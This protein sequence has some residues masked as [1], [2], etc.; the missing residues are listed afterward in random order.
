MTLRCDGSKQVRG[1]SSQSTTAFT[2]E[3]VARRRETVQ[4]RP[5]LVGDFFTRW[6]GSAPMSVGWSRG[7]S[8]TPAPKAW[9]APD[10]CAEPLLPVTRLGIR[11]ADSLK[12]GF[13]RRIRTRCRRSGTESAGR[14]A[15]RRAAHSWC[16]GWRTSFGHRLCPYR[17]VQD[18]RIGHHAPERSRP[19]CRLL[20]FGTPPAAR[21]AASDV[22]S[23]APVDRCP[24]S[25]PSCLA[26]PC[27]L[28]RRRT[29]SARGRLRRIR[30]ERAS[31]A[32]GRPKGSCRLRRSSSPYG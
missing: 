9:R 32:G 10:S 30:A 24:D 1:G 5:L 26:Y 17:S 31:G 27:D 29:G 6:A 8:D 4:A 22:V 15:S 18:I 12:R 28:G 16:T 14:R 7:E 23:A 19:A 20:P 13:G 25:F 3:L 21:P 11:C 2:W